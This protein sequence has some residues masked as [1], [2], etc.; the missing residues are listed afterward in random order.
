[1]TIREEPLRLHI[2]GE[3]AKAGWKIFNV[4]PGRDVD[5]TG[6]C[7]DLSAFEDASVDDIYAS[8]VLEHLG[9]QE[10]LPRALAE[11]HRVLKNGGRARI[12]VPDFEILCKLFL[13]ARQR[14]PERIMIMRMAFGGQLDPDDF[15]YVGLSFDILGELLGNAGFS[16]IE[17]VSEFG[18]FSDTSS[19]RILDTLVSLNVVV[20]K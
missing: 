2:G 14:L 1:M 20:Y 7:A 10:R 12:S 3:E 9:Y 8:H 15:H 19:A 5:Y 13:E 17:R 18:L 16:R 4:K 11:F 6:D